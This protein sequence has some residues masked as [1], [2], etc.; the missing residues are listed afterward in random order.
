M[1]IHVLDHHICAPSKFC[2]K[3]PNASQ[4][5]LSSLLRRSQNR[6]QS[7]EV[8]CP[9]ASRPKSTTETD[10][11]QPQ[12]PMQVSG[13]SSQRAVETAHFPCVL[14]PSKSSAHLLWEG[15][16]KFWCRDDHKRRH[17]SLASGDLFAT[18]TPTPSRKGSVD[19]GRREQYQHGKLLGFDG[20]P[21]R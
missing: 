10:L 18:G 8:A 19:C 5:C 11:L 1:W 15:C 6:V 17:E 13:M 16:V 20:P 2:S 3:A 14:H 12:S 9:C 4:P 7:I 21:R